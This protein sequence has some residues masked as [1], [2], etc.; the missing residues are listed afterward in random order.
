MLI[1]G[2]LL[3]FEGITIVFMFVRVGAGMCL[4]SLFTLVFLFEL[5]STVKYSGYLVAFVSVLGES[6]LAA[7]LNLRCK[8]AGYC[9]VCK[10]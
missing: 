10:L 8:A 3:F 1:I 2:A 4:S 6:W 5:F 9:T 7:S